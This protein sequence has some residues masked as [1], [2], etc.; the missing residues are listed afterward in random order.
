MLC[1]LSFLLFLFVHRSLRFLLGYLQILCGS[2][3]FVIPMCSFHFSMAVAV[4]LYF[5][6]GCAI[7]IFYVDM[8]NR[9]ISLCVNRSEE[10]AILCEHYNLDHSYAAVDDLGSTDD[11]VRVHR[12][13]R[14]AVRSQSHNYSS[15]SGGGAAAHEQDSGS[16]ADQGQD[17]D[18]LEEEDIDAIIREEDKNKRTDFWVGILRACS[19]NRLTA[20]GKKVRVEAKLAVISEED[21]VQV[22]QKMLRGSVLSSVAKPPV[23]PPVKKPP[24]VKPAARKDPL[25]PSL[26]AVVTIDREERKRRQRIELAHA[27]ASE[28]PPLHA[29]MADRVRRDELFVL[30]EGSYD[31]PMVALALS[32]TGTLKAHQ[33][34]IVAG[35]SCDSLY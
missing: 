6:Y 23:K 4:C 10:S 2:R 16:D 28:Y 14:Q 8:L 24:V 22:S 15:S 33:V 18:P 25:T 9:S 27:V 30:N 19:R 13:Y 12:E 11:L 35:T 3:H 21:D 7:L 17:Q 1:E 31:E 32:L 34:S 29:S 26:A 5:S 20:G